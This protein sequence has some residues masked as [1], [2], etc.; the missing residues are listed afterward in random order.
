MADKTTFILK[1]IKEAEYLEQDPPSIPAIFDATEFKTKV[2]SMSDEEFY[3]SYDDVFREV[4]FFDYTLTSFKYFQEW[5]T[6]DFLEVGCGGGR[7]LRAVKALCPV[8]RCVGVDASHYALSVA[9][10]VVPEEVEVLWGD[11][12][13]RLPFEDGSFDVVLCGHTLE[14]LRYPN[15]AVEEIKKVSR[16]HVI[17]LIPLQSEGER[18]KKTN[19]HIQFWPIIQK[20]EDF[21]GSEASK[22]LNL[23]DGTLAIM[24]FEM[25]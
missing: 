25:G 7:T 11:V 13:K 24:L 12:E 1:V 9:R 3:R 6:G 18:W 21:F 15:R 22:V 2:W 8:K 5:I 14:H 23:R 19:L 4:G 10:T 17:I 20:F 16:K